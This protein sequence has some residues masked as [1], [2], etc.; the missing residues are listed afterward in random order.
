MQRRHCGQR[1]AHNELGD[2]GVELLHPCWRLYE[3]A[4]EL[5]DRHSGASSRIHP[6]GQPAKHPFASARFN[7]F[8]FSFQTVIGQ[9]YIVEYKNELNNGNWIGLQTNAG[10]GGITTV[11]N[12]ISAS[13]RRFFR[14][15]LP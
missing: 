1:R 5:S 4:F 8:L 11:T 10:D 2:G 13:P 7:R 9:T 12:L 14:L 3:R 6:R 15:R